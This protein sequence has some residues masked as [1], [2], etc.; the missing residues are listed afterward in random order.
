MTVRPSRPGLRIS[1]GRDERDVGDS[2]FYKVKGRRWCFTINN[3]SDD[4]CTVV[5]GMDAER[6]ICGKELAPSTGTPH[7]QG[8]ARFKNPVRASWWKTI[9]PRAHL[10][11][12]KGSDSENEVYCTKEAV[13]LINKGVNCDETAPKMSREE[14]TD[15]VISEIESGAKYGQ[16]R[17][18]H[19]RFCFWH[20]KNILD[21][22]RDE[23]FLADYPDSDPVS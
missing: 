23:K 19:K 8:Y 6:L 1:P 17:Q 2:A 12:A 18:R 3:Y 16:I 9:L 10:E 21:Y 15:Q 7:L 11:L 22:M 20:R 13:V 4:E 5:M 14:E